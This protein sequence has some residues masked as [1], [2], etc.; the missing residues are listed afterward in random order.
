MHSHSGA[1]TI[2]TTTLCVQAS[3]RLDSTAVVT[4][5]VTCVRT[6][7]AA[8]TAAA[9]ALVS[10]CRHCVY[11]VPALKKVAYAKFSDYAQYQ[12][13]YTH[14]GDL[15]GSRTHTHPHDTHMGQG[16]TTTVTVTTQQGISVVTVNSSE[17]WAQFWGPQQNFVI[18][19]L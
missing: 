18:Q 14:I 15:H 7:S 16:T 5:A 3:K 4:A 12:H 10:K 2:T 19:S 17:W 13:T 6:Y 8:A 9:A 1:I 11:A